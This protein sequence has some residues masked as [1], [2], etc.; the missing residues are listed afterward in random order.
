MIQPSVIVT[1]SW[2]SCGMCCSSG[3]GARG[4]EPSPSLHTALSHLQDLTGQEVPAHCWPLGFIA[5]QSTSIFCICF[6]DFFSFNCIIKVKCCCEGGGLLTT[7]NAAGFPLLHSLSWSSSR[8][9]VKCC[10][11]G[12]RIPTCAN[13][14]QGRNL[15]SCRAG[16]WINVDIVGHLREEWCL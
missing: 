13:T 3:R 9:T 16:K 4:G 14:A 11:C 1:I 7:F 10:K 5:L 12:S 8:L 15:C 2:P 6:V